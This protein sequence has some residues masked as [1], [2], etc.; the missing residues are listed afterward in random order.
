MAE[1]RYDTKEE[2]YPELNNRGGGKN[3][4]RE[5]SRQKGFKKTRMNQSHKSK[6]L[7]SHERKGYEA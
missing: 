2:G 6:G 7:G 3:L 1:A 5:R 4:N